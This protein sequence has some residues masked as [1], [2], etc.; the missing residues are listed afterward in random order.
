MW[1]AVDTP[2]VGYRQ[3]GVGREHGVLGFEEYL[4]TKVIALPLRG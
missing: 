4:Q 2:F 1:F 3:S